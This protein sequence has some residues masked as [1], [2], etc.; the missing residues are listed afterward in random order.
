LIDHPPPPQGT[1]TFR[2]L[3]LST[4]YK[5]FPKPIEPIKPILSSLPKPLSKRTTTLCMQVPWN[6]GDIEVEH[7]LFDR[8]SALPAILRV[9]HVRDNTIT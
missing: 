4:P 1:L 7:P 5:A 9:S 6:G 3:F 2:S 8:R